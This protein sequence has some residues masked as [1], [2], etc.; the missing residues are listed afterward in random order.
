MVGVISRG[1]GLLVLGLVAGCGASTSAPGGSGGV[2][3]GNGG[4]GGNGSLGGASVKVI[5]GD[6]QTELFWDLA[7]RGTALEQ[8][9]G[10]RVSVRMGMP[11][12][13]P[14]RLASGQAQIV[15][16]AFE[17]FFPQ[18]W[19]DSL[20]KLKLVYIDLDQDEVCDVARDRLWA[21]ARF[22]VTPELIVRGVGERQG[23]DMFL[24]DSASYC[25]LFNAE[26]PSQ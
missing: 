25:E 16:G 3:Q 15:D 21:D 9:E 8:Y 19:E 6:P 18:V 5:R 2:T 14:E 17:L 26:W 20:Y 4:S 23:A 1:A 22:V 13:P 24:S 11:S 12:R 10:R 7:I